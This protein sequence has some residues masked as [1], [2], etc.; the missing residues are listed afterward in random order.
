MNGDTPIYTM[1]DVT[2][3]RSR[4]LQIPE[5]GEYYGDMLRVEAVLKNRTLP[6]EASSLLCSM[7][8][9]RDEKRRRMVEH[10][11]RKRNIPTDEMWQQLINGTYKPLESDELDELAAESSESS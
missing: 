9:Q 6:Q 11:A 4:R 10:L 8:Q 5:L 1:L 3:A 7:L 2:M